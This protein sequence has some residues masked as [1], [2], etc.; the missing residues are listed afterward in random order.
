[1][2]CAWVPSRVYRVRGEA[3]AGRSSAGQ[4]REEKE[5]RPLDSAVAN[6]G[7]LACDRRWDDVTECL[8]D[9]AWRAEGANVPAEHQ[10]SLLLRLD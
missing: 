1:M 4:S 8:K 3:V 9:P 10:T 2:S 7:D 6:S 5:R